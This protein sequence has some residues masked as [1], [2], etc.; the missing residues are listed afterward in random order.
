FYG[1]KKEIKEIIDNIDKKVEVYGIGGVGKSKLVDIVLLLQKFKGKKVISVGLGHHNEKDSSFYYT[2]RNNDKQ[3]FIVDNHI[4]NIYHVLEA[5]SE[6]VKNIEDIE[7]NKEDKIIS[8]ILNVIKE[9]NVLLFIDDFQNVNESV[10]NL[11]K[12]LDNI[13]IASRKLTGLADKEVFLTGIQEEFRENLVNRYCKLLN[14]DPDE[15]I[16]RKIQNFAEGHPL[17]TQLLLRNIDKIIVE[18]IDELNLKYFDINQV[19]EYS[20]HVF[21]QI[22]STDALSLLG[23]IAVIDTELDYNLEREIVE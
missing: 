21:K 3:H 17:S 18:N 7:K 6:L 4:I 2:N 15:N 11:V 12:K 16:K 1:R 14:V 9:N 22:L 13:I 23:S 19:R 5:M 10:I 20:D 8:I